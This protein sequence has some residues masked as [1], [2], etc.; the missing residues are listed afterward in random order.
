MKQMY[1]LCFLLISGLSVKAQSYDRTIDVIDYEIFLK[2]VDSSDR[3]EVDEW[4]RFNWLDMSREVRFDLVSQNSQ[5][6]GMKIDHVLDGADTLLFQH[7]EDQLVVRPLAV[8]ENG[9]VQLKLRFSGIPA[10]GLII[11]KNKFGERTFFGDNWPDRAHHWFACVDHPSDKATVSFQVQAPDK[12]N[13]VAVGK[14]LSEEARGND[15]FYFFRSNVPLPTKVMVV[16]IAE[17]SFDHLSSRSGI[18]IVNAVYKKESTDVAQDMTV[19]PEILDFFEGYIS[20]YEYEELENVQSTTRYGGMENAGCIFYDENAFNGR[21]TGEDLMAHE[22]AHQWFGNS[23]S[24]SDWQH[25]WLSEG[26]ATYLTNLYLRNKYGE[27]TFDSQL[28]K[29]RR[30]VIQ[31]ARSYTHPI[32][33]TAYK[34]LE[35]LLN[36]NSYQKG[37]WVLHMLHHELGDSIFHAAIKEYYGRFRLSNASTADLQLVFEKVSGRDLQFFFDQWLYNSGHPVLKIEIVKSKGKRVLR[38]EQVQSQRPFI[39]PI[40][41]RL[42]L[43]DGVSLDKN[44]M[45]TGRITEFILDT[46]IPVIRSEPDPDTDLLFELAK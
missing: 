9:E 2:V 6:N 13:V 35:S 37:S 7:V 27:K 40:K 20:R 31:F 3:I 14:L 29:D 44:L 12:Y 17:F 15:H 34:Q 28:A 42:E 41:I 23:A 4:I 21:L 45:V 25:V 19:A 5:G 36:A 24:E 39:F 11:S 26:F 43:K 1:A 38:V 16:G 10:D 32:V 30:K 8:S 46:A 18:P 33:D 22:I